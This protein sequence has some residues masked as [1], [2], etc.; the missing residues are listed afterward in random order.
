[1]L[2]PGKLKLANREC[3]LE[4][5]R[6]KSNYRIDWGQNLGHIKTENMVEI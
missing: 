5:S 4:Q 6:M 1:M 2:Q 3:N